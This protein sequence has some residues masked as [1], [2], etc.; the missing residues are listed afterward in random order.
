MLLILLTFSKTRTR[1]LKLKYEVN[2][3]KQ[4][5]PYIFFVFSLLYSTNAF[6]SEK[7]EMR[8]TSGT[9]FFISSNKIVTN[10][11]VVK[12]CDYIRIRGSIPAAFGKVIAKNIDD[13]LAII[14]TSKRTKYFA[15]IS[16]DNN[17]RVSQPITI[18][19]Y[20]LQ[21]GIDGSYV[22][23]NDFITDTKDGFYSDKRF[24]FNNII[25]KGSSGGPVIDQYGAIIGVIAGKVSFYFTSDNNKKEKPIKTSSV[26]INQ[27]SL[28][29]F[30]DENN[31]GYHIRDSK[32]IIAPNNIESRIDD[33][34]V[35]IHCLKEKDSI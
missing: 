11:H 16:S 9:G 33:Y 4:V 22:I 29:N 1:S 34:L 35:N 21:H 2:I 25:E 15:K 12:S 3:M 10:A 28:K 8:F 5:V 19:S 32:K 24:Q 23:Q 14:R 13:D 6:S 26:A 27:K 17:L 31:I 18:A 20:P 7:R 30:L